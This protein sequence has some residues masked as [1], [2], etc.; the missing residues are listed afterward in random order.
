MMRYITGRILQGALV[1][2]A[3][4]TV[5]FFLL[6]ALPSDPI[7][8]LLGPDANDVSAEQRAELAA[9]YGFDRPALVQ[10]GQHLVA[11]LRGDL[12]FSVQL[13]RPVGEVL[14]GALGATGQIAALGLVLALVVGLGLGLATAALRGTWF[15]QVLLG[16]PS[17]GVSIPAFW[18]GLMLIQIFSFRLRLLPAFSADGFAGL[19]LPAVTLALPTSATIAQVFARSLIDQRRQPYA[20]TVVDEGT[21]YRYVLVRH[22]T[23]NALLP[24]L[25]IAGLVVGQL[26]SGTVVTETVF[27]RAGLG[28]VIATAVTGQDFP[29][30]L[31]AVLIGAALYSGTNLMVDLVY[32][33]VDPRLRAHLGRQ[34]QSTPPGGGA[35]EAAA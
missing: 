4:Y 28:R 19:I 2:W 5:A 16:L 14:G 20:H 27:S 11:L 25:T 13:S 9:R 15:S 6:F 8:L 23:R 29:V 1:I 32:P 22:V 17:L 31:G 18:F 30:V 10:Y 26:F 12:G 7:S 24:V 35:Q 3:A 33:L 21:S 34:R